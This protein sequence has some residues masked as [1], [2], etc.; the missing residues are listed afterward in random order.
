IELDLDEQSIAEIA[1]IENLQR[2]DLTIWEEADGLASLHSR[3]GYTHEDIAKKI[4]KSRTTVTESMT[5]AGIP[6]NIREK[7]RMAKINA[8][9]TLLEIA[10]QFDDAEM[11][12]F[13]EQISQKGLTREEVRQ[14][15]R[16]KLNQVNT[17][18]NQSS[19]KKPTTPKLNETLPQIPIELNNFE[20]QAEDKSFNL[21]IQF[22][23]EFDKK[24]ILRALKE[25]FEKV[26]A[27]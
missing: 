17:Q 6:D 22:G 23:T 11:I 9:S 16:P 8:K 14:S 3:F 19:L 15:A 13:I 12:R 18:T 25:T 27:S 26:K 5:I 4:G 24:D 20:Y 7:C 21:T 2:K 10:R 1:L